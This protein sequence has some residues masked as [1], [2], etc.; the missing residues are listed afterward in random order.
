MPE[1]KKSKDITSQI[2][3]LST[4]FVFRRDH[5]PGTSCEEA[6]R[7]GIPSAVIEC[8]NHH[9]SQTIQTAQEHIINLLI[10]FG[11]IDSEKPIHPSESLMTITEYTGIE[12]IVPDVGFR[13]LLASERIY[14]G[15]PISQGELYAVSDRG[16]YRAPVDCTLFIPDPKP[17]PTD[18][19][20]GFLTTV[21][22]KKRSLAQTAHSIKKRN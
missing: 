20:A 1:D 21:T 17:H 10:Y 4:R 6:L 13:W 18:H 3:N 22:S 7:H 12:P 16:E 15:S 14:S 9:H 19:D 5:A 8:G 11:L 2:T